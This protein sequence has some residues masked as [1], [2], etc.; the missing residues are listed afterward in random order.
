[1]STRKKNADLPRQGKLN[2]NENNDGQDDEQSSP[3]NGETSGEVSGGGVARPEGPSKPNPAVRPLD[4]A[5]MLMIGDEHVVISSEEN[6][7]ISFMAEF[8][9][10]V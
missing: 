3:Q 2:N 5:A 8:I 7:N 1:M 9:D 6:D 4:L 10:P